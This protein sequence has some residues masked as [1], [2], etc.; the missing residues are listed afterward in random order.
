MFDWD[1]A[2]IAHIA[3]HDV[4]PHDVV[5]HEAEEAYNSHPL[6]LDYRVEDW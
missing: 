5:P 3:R 4:V 2:N 6:F 1:Q